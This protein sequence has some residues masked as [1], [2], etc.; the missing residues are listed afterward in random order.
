MTVLLDIYVSNYIYFNRIDYC[1]FIDKSN[2][3]LLRI[4]SFN[5][6]FD[7]INFGTK[8]RFV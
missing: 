7:Y 8:S 4:Q 1:L 2:D 5:D 3:G 6:Y